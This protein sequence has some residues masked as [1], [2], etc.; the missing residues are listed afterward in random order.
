MRNT[1]I[2]KYI[3]RST[4]GTLQS[5]LD[6]NFGAVFGILADFLAKTLPAPINQ[7]LTSELPGSRQYN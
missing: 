4:E 3:Q 7:G 6:T 2:Y 5:D 1:R